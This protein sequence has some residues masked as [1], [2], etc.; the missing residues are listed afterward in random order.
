V[1]VALCYQN[2]YAQHRFYELGGAT[3]LDFATMLCL[4]LI[5]ALPR[6]R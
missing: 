4:V 2:R 3:L 6:L 5:Q 1:I